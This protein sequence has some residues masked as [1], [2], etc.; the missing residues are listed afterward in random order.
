[1]RVVPCSFNRRAIGGYGGNVC[2]RMI[3][4]SG[5]FEGRVGAGTGFAACAEAGRGFT[6]T[7]VMD[8]AVTSEFWTANTGR[9]A[10]GGIGFT[11]SGGA[12]GGSLGIS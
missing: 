7:V 4:R 3:G 5:S 9:I 8:G 6:G 11:K 10:A 1:M 12:G 2:V